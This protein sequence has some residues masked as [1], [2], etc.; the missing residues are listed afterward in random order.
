ME[1]LSQIQHYGFWF[2]VV[3]TVL[4]FIHELGH[5][6][7]ARWCGV[8]VEVFSIG[9]GPELFGWTDKTGTRWK[10]SWLPLGGYVRMF[11]QADSALE[12][13][14]A[15][16]MSDAERAVSFK[17]KNVGQRMAIVAAGPAANFLFAIVVLAVLYLA[18]GRPYT[19]PVV[20]MLTPGS[21]AAEAGLQTGDR[22]LAMNGAAVT[23]FGDIEPIVQ[24]NL[25]NPLTITVDRAG[26][27]IEL[28]AHPKIET[29]KNLFGDS[30]RMAQLGIAP[31]LEP[32]LGEV[33]S[34]SAAA[35]AGLKA[36]DRL[37]AL[38][39]KPVIDFGQV[40]RIVR[41]NGDQP[42]AITVDRAG[43]RLELTARPT[44][45]E[46]KDES[47]KTV[48]VPR[49]GVAAEAPQTRI[50]VGPI[51]ATI[52]A[53][54]EVWNQ[55]TMMLTGL[56]Q[57]LTLQRSSEDIRGVMTIAKTA[58][59]VASLGFV[60]FIGFSVM[61]S[62]NLGLINLFPVPMLDGGHLVY[63]A[64]EAIRGKPLSERVQEFGLKVGLALVL[65]LML[66]ATWNDLVYLKV[67][68]FV[69]SL[70]T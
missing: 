20:G 69:K 12:G 37:M 46:G 49:L 48:R 9:F 21:A 64:A 32:V 4:V 43:T 50:D 16:P 5:F 23:E 38:N 45:V 60:S 51:E 56:W 70:F 36:G 57:M 10:I 44:M 8:R 42:L 68:D 66:F 55:S 17:D 33:V 1:I 25:E 52:A 30:V 53:G 62:I 35:A 65:S 58:G 28:T 19:D 18:M 27:Q 59:D 13:E 61:L 15:R 40:V 2:L 26:K 67:V 14:A 11:G 41:E 63:Y 31:H 3:L 47:G 39:G 22:I 24:L 6:A 34:E 54:R 29:I 7:V